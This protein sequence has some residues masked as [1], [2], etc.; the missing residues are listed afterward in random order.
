MAPISDIYRERVRALRPSERMRLVE[1]IARDLAGAPA[2]ETAARPRWMDVAGIAPDLLAEEY[3][4]RW[5]SDS[6][7]E[8]DRRRA[9]KP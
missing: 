6:R 5:V 3:A 8:S 9:L 7:R 2:D 1:L 4:Q